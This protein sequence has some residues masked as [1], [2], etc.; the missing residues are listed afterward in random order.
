MGTETVSAVCNARHI[1]DRSRQ[2]AMWARTIPTRL[3]VALRRGMV[4]FCNARPWLSGGF[5]WTGFDYRGEPSPI[6]VAEHQLAVRHHRHCADSPRTPSSTTSHGGRASRCCTCFRTG[7][8][9]EWKARRSRSGCTRTWT[10]WS[11]FQNGKSLGVKE[12]QEGLARGVE[13]EVRA[14]HD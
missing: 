5:V 6:P 11:L 8:G 9:R 10:R 12:V 1:R 4:G 14:G 2:R 13:R 7:T 3:P